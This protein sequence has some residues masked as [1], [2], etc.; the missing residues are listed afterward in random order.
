MAT[1]KPQVYV[2]VNSWK[3]RHGDEGLNVKVFGT[4]K[5]ADKYFA[6][7]LTHYLSEMDAIKADV[8][9]KDPTKKLIKTEAL[10]SFEAGDISTDECS[11]KD[12]LA[13]ATKAGC[14]E[15]N[16]DGSGTYASW[17]VAKQTVK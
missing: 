11:L 1:K 8:F 10:N 7:D 3:D 9:G 15:V 12:F 14:A 6:D 16:V 4:K 5:A 17:S 2:F 13:K